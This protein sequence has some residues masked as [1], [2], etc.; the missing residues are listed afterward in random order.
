MF[1]LFVVACVLLCLYGNRRVLSCCGEPAL[2]LL[3]TYQVSDSHPFAPI[4]LHCNCATYPRATCSCRHVTAIRSTV[5]RLNLSNQ[6]MHARDRVA[7]ADEGSRLRGG[8][9]AGAGGQTHMRAQHEL[10]LQPVGV[11]TAAAAGVC[12]QTAAE[13]I[14]TITVVVGW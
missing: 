10:Y 5:L 2:K 12:V 4:H 9:P 14:G 6:I 7:D 8:V 1:L 11:A 13:I 3:R